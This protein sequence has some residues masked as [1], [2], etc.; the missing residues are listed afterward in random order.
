MNRILGKLRYYAPETAVFIFAFFIRFFRLNIPKTYIFDEVYHAFTAEQMFKGNPA[1]WE[2]WNTPPKGFAYEWTHPPIAKEFMVVAIKVFGDGSFAW[3]FFSAFFGALVIVLIYLL[4]YKLFKNRLVA[5][6]AALTASFDGLLLT[7]SRIAMNDMYLLFFLLLGFLL[8]LH[9]K[10][11]L[12]GVAIGLSIA[13]KWTGF[14][15]IPILSL[16]YILEEV[17]FHKKGIR[18]IVFKIVLLVL[19][20]VVVPTIVYLLSYLPF[21]TGKHALQGANQSNQQQTVQ[22]EQTEQ[23][24]SQYIVKSGDTLWGIAQSN[25]GDGNSWRAITGY[26]GSPMQLPVG[27]IL[28]IP[29][30]TRSV[31]SIEPS[32]NSLPTEQSNSASESSFPFNINTFIELQ[33][34]MYWYHTNLKAHHTYESKPVQWLLDLRP[35]WF[36]VD[37]KGNF[38]ANIY[39]LGNP[40]FM[41]AGFSSIIFMFLQFTKK[42]SFKFIFVL[43]S[44]LV[45]F[46]PWLFSPR[47]MF[48]YHYLP[49]TPF[50]SISLGYALNEVI[51][52]NK[53]GPILVG[54]FICAMAILFIYFLPLW[55]AISVPKEIYESYFWFK[56]WK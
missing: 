35:V 55:T 10:Y 9:K 26:N 27:I 16:F 49:S 44:Y 28:S 36:Y 52:R 43:V 8:F 17:K 42:R 1:A 23:S 24:S 13:S 46:V 34:Q 4:A 11:L 12:A 3:R 22:R 21:F 29:Q 39:N 38:I 37:Y 14:F 50:L 31:E 20:F 5:I 33:Q 19:Y 15:A 47:I 2:W 30:P 41:W 40:I 32:N 48:Y 54:I 45:F 51:E 25:L 6:L 7:M 18:K 53:Y 56:S